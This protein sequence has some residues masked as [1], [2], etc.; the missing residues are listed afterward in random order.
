MATHYINNTT[1]DGSTAINL[2]GANDQYGSTPSWVYR[3]SAI[4]KLDSWTVDLTVR[5]LSA[6]VVS[7]AL[8][9]C[10]GNC[11][12]V[13]ANNYPYLTINDNHVAGAFYLDGS[14]AKAFNVGGSGGEV[15]LAVT[16][17]LDKNPPLSVEP[18]YIGNEDTPGE[19]QTN[20]D[21]YDVLGRTF[22]FGVRFQ[23]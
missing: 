14:I 12:A 17:I 19:P 13:T 7:H 16:N 9:Q 1:N 22:R 4:Y 11:P 18:D 20:R 21:L 8:T 5:G 23:F 10:S 3:L 6:G 2:A 15:F